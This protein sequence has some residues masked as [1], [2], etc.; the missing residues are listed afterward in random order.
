MRS[1][2]IGK[3]RTCIRRTFTACS[4]YAGFICVKILL[5]TVLQGGVAYHSIMNGGD[6]YEEL[7][8]P[9]LNAL[10]NVHSGF[11]YIYISIQ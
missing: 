9:R 8:F 6:A 4:L 1:Q 3:K 10:R 11:A 2:K 7:L 5:T